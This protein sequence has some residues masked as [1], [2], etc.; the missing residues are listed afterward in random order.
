MALQVTI[1][2]ITG[3]SPYDVYICQ[4]GGTSCFYMTTIT[5]TPYIFDIPAPY[6]TSE[7]YMLKIIDNEGCVI[8]GIEPVTICADVTPTLTTTPTPTATPCVCQGYEINNPNA[9][10]IEVSWVDCD[11]INQSETVNGP[12]QYIDIC[13]CLDSVEILEGSYEISLI[14]CEPTLTV[15]STPT[16]TPTPTNIN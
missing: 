14:P 12:D 1:D 11:G 7:A 16:V 6:D 8:T 9:S 5:T 4:T 2:S 13:A 3:Q 15:T 10:P